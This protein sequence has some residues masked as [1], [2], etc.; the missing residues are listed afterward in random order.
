MRSLLRNV[1]F[2]C[3]LISLVLGIAGFALPSLLST[4]RGT[5]SIAQFLSSRVDGEIQIRSLQL[6]WQGPLVLQEVLWLNKDGSPLLEVPEVRVEKGLWG[7]L[8]STSHLGTVRILSPQVYLQ[9]D[10]KQNTPPPKTKQV[11][12]SPSKS[13]SPLSS[14][15]RRKQWTFRLP[16]VGNFILENARL[17]LLQENSSSIVFSGVDAQ[18]T[19]PSLQGPLKA[20]LLASTNTSK[21]A[22]G[23]LELELNIRGFDSSGVFQMSSD[24][25]SLPHPI[26]GGEIEI[27][28]NLERI[29][30]DFL[31][32]LITLKYPRLFG[33]LSNGL[34]KELSLTFTGRLNSKE[35][36]LDSSIQTPHLN[37][38]L[39]GKTSQALFELAPHSQIHGKIPPSFVKK[40]I[41]QLLPQAQTIY[42]QEEALFSFSL[43]T[44][45]IPFGRGWEAQKVQMDS[46]FSIQ[47]Q[48][49]LV[50]NQKSPLQLHQWSTRVHTDDITENI[51]GSLLVKGVF[52]ERDFQASLQGNLHSLFG[53]SGEFHP[54]QSTLHISSRL[55]TLP[56][57]LLDA[58][59]GSRKECGTLLGSQIQSISSLR[60][61]PKGMQLQF[62]LESPHLTLPSVSLHWKEGWTLAQP[63]SIH[64]HP[65]QPIGP[66]ESGDFFVEVDKGYLDPQEI[67]KS[68]LNLQG[69]CSNALL[70]LSDQELLRISNCSFSTQKSP[71]EDVLFSI[72]GSLQDA[73]SQGWISHFLAR[74]GHFKSQGSLQ[75]SK[76]QPWS[77]TPW[78]FDLEMDNTTL[79]LQGSLDG[80]GNVQFTAPI[81][82]TLSLS[83]HL[84]QAASSP[85]FLSQPAELSLSIFPLEFNWKKSPLTTLSF[86]GK[87]TLSAV[88]LSQGIEKSPSLKELT[89][90]WSFS[91]P[92]GKTEVD[93]TGFTSL[94][95]NAPQ[96]PLSAH[97]ECTHPWDSK[98]KVNWKKG[99]IKGSLKT[100]HFPLSLL[101][102][103]SGKALYQSDLQENVDV[104]AQLE[105]SD[106]Q[107]PSGQAELQVQSSHLQTSAAFNFGE[108]IQ[109]TRP[110]SLQWQLSPQ[111]LSTLYSFFGSQWGTIPQLQAPCKIDLNIHQL[112][113]PYWWE[114][115]WTLESM[116]LQARA[117]I[118]QAQLLDPKTN[119]LFGIQSIETSIQTE[120][121]TKNC[122]LELN[123]KG[124]W[125]QTPFSVQ[126][127]IILDKTPSPHQ[128]LPNLNWQGE[129]VDFPITALAQT[130][131]LQQAIQNQLSAILGSTATI[132]T[133]GHLESDNGP[134]DLQIHSKKIQ[135]SIAAQ[136]EKGTLTL[137]KPL[138]AKLSS[139]PELSR[140][141]LKHVH[142]LLIQ[143]YDAEAPFQLQIPPKNFSLPLYP[144][145]W[146]Q[147]SIEKATLSLGKV[148]CTNG[149]LLALLVGIFHVE[150]RTP[151]QMTIWFTPLHFDVKQGFLNCQRMDALIANSFHICTWGSIDLTQ[152]KVRMFIGFPEDTLRYAFGI[153]ELPQ[154][155]VLQAPL[156]GT[157]HRP[158][159]D[160]A[161]ALA[162]LATLRISTGQKKEKQPL[163]KLINR[164]LS[165]AVTKE[166]KAP[167]P[168]TTPFPWSQEWTQNARGKES[169]IP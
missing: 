82:T 118:T 31:D 85:T 18:I 35:L 8:R 142:P 111:V 5:Q 74:K 126:N 58:L 84:F 11:A 114:T 37:G 113:V 87:A 110:L 72:E 168:T 89:A 13:S 119:H 129:W 136:V 122:Y 117:A 14:H 104:L 134:L 101:A 132:T 49:W 148:H 128:Q 162:K 73:D 54:L 3:L 46:S 99:A 43:H 140:A 102:A 109:L 161:T 30:T 2:I 105:L 124:S 25:H 164:V 12:P 159:L 141:T 153:Q 10:Q 32:S 70:R 121:K 23:S 47:A 139:S 29:P 81:N 94:Q 7:F 86:G 91:G 34:G 6:N 127:K 100:Q 77:I 63:A 53:S 112:Q 156:K 92:E 145:D 16:F 38:R 19:I 24:V 158:K 107:H 103:L 62:D 66:W 69:S 68:H 163:G 151:R 96:T 44:L 27:Q 165:S 50:G 90:S 116:T 120:Q 28:T 95:D 26:S 146:K 57:S 131:N 108:T 21:E 138:I 152:E 9:R 135:T 1:L 80:K 157:I 130:T 144:F 20:S 147:V 149:G 40:Y 150:D 123:S 42:P 65:K 160:L 93:M 33:I 64:F 61:S 75:L 76:T 22:E 88:Q 133:R 169:V 67:H 97:I 137:K 56:S 155:Y 98:E 60:L 79:A 125:N 83:P 39:G 71:L 4:K 115:P 59:Y 166:N 48:Q 154:D 167:L 41:N 45:K 78:T 143:A 52:E 17:E 51:S 15:L 55:E 106:F 36:Q